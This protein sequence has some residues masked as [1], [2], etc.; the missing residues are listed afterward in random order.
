V[1]ETEVA[2]EQVQAAKQSTSEDENG[3]EFRVESEQPS[4]EEEGFFQAEAKSMGK[5]NGVV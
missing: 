1:P 5:S 4:S 2:A 3:D